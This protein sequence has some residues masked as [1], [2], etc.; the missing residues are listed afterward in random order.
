MQTETS[1]MKTIGVWIWLNR[2]L[3]QSFERSDRMRIV[4]MPGWFWLKHISRMWSISVRGSQTLPR[5]PKGKVEWW[6]AKGSGGGQSHWGFKWQ[7]FCRF[8]LKQTES[9]KGECPLECS[10]KFPRPWGVLR[11][12]PIVA[13]WS[14]PR[15]ET[16]LKEA[17]GDLESQKSKHP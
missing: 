7:V 14:C 13:S 11:Y 16:P 10:G 2:I 17:A 9:H 6:N 15:T 5:L 12:R 1:V 3:R 8:V 4:L